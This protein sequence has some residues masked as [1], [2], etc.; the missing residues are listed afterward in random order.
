MI[1]FSCGFILMGVVNGNKS[2]DFNGN[3]H[4]FNIWQIISFGQ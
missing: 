3:N 2:M 1:I 4:K